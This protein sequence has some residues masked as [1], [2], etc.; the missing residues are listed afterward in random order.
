MKAITS[1]IKRGEIHNDTLQDICAQSKIKTRHPTTRY[2]DLL[3][4]PPPSPFRKT[5]HKHTY[6]TKQ[7]THLL[8]SLRLSSAFFACTV[9]LCISLS[10]FFNAFPL[11]TTNAILCVLGSSTT[12][13]AFRSPSPP[14]PPPVV[15]HQAWRNTRTPPPPCSYTE[16]PPPCSSRAGLAPLS[17]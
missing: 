12:P 15:Q 5:M 17:H 1:F 7:K 13:N 4:L 6:N 3:T 9:L 10:T 14:F 16:P 2:T 11:A 8:T